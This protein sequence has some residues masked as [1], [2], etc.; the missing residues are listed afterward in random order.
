VRSFPGRGLVDT[1]FSARNRF[2]QLV[3]LVGVASGLTGALYIAVLKGLTKLLG[4]DAWSDPAHLV[5][6]GA[7]GLAIGL[8]TLVLGNPGDVELLVNNIHVNGGRSDIRDL[9]S[10]IPVSLLGIAAGSAI[11]P[12]APLVQTTGSI[13]NWVAIRRNLGVVDSRSLT[14]TGMAA[15]FALLFGA[16][17][18]SAIFALEILHRRG[19]EYYEALLPAALGALTGYALYIGVNRIGLHPIW[20]FPEPHDLRAIDL[21]VGIAAGVIGAVVASAFTYFVR[22]EQRVFRLLP[23]AV[24]PVVGGLAL[25]GLAFASPYALTFGEGQIQHVASFRLAVG[26]L[27]L[28]ALVKFVASSTIISAGW[29]GGFIIPLFFMGAVLGGALARIVH[30]DPV[31]AMAAGMVAC[32]VGVTKT[33][34]GS[35][36]VVAEMAGMRLIPSTF[37]A[38]LVAL[39]LTSRVSMIHAQRTRQG[40]FDEATLDGA[41]APPVTPEVTTDPSV[42]PAN[43]PHGSP[44]PRTTAPLDAAR[45]GRATSK[46]RT[47]GSTG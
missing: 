37:L 29:R 32:N 9:R 17:L 7:V 45:P 46:P 25:G 26:T 16:P 47:E 6:L 43:P 20:Q 19:L 35:T 36:L 5:V 3:L 4:A 15:G 27:L 33:P 39:F 22:L 44:E 1:T 24:R 30:V 12:E 18:G 31:I 23:P 21:L 28:A 14:I 41:G 40:V 42:V 34:Y 2:W 38:A 10:L 11:G 13:G 8:L